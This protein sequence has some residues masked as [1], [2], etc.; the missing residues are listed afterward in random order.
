M[1][2]FAFPDGVD[3]LES[4]CLITT[5]SVSWR[6][7]ESDQQWRDAETRE[8]ECARHDNRTIFSGS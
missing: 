4:V 7:D 1:L 6:R 3:T 5:V 2:V 8:V